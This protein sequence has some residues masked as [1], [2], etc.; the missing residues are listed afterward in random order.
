M[1]AYN[2]DRGKITN[3]GL[4]HQEEIKNQTWPL[5]CCSW[6]CFPGISYP[7]RAQ[8]TPGVPRS[9]HQQTEQASAHTHIHTRYARARALDGMLART[10]IHTVGVR[11]Y[12]R[13]RIQTR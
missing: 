9:A 7:T 4:L 2:A 10:R 13:A 1:P 5:L 11:V 12:M 6:V 8:V 3:L